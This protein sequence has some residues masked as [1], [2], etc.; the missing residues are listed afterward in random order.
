MGAGYAMRNSTRPSG[1]LD[2]LNTRLLDGLAVTPDLEMPIIR[3]DLLDIPEEIAR[4]DRKYKEHKGDTVHLYTEDYRFEVWWSRPELTTEKMIESGWAAV[5][6]PDF[7]AFRDWNINNQRQNVFRSRLLGAYAQSRGI[8]VIPTIQWAGPKSYEFCFD[9]IPE[10]SMVSI[11]TVGV[12]RDREARLL[13]LKGYE[14]MIDRIRPRAVLAY[15]KLENLLGELPDH[16]YAYAPDA[17]ARRSP[18]HEV[19]RRDRALVGDYDPIP[20]ACRARATVAEKP[21]AEKP[22]AERLVQEILA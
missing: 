17:V 12:H 1:S 2:V 9:G 16:V 5:F 13:F 4:W 11:S 22:A 21:A 20:E 14:E 8:P 15:G 10:G 3:D 19:A 6:S 18:R 7:S